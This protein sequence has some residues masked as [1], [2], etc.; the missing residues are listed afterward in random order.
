MLKRQLYDEGLAQ[1]R[2]DREHQEEMQAL[3]WQIANGKMKSSDLPCEQ[4]KL[5]MAWCKREEC[6]IQEKIRKTDEQIEKIDGLLADIAEIKK[7]SD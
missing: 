2:W 3:F 6:R 1:E 7:M 5:L 4:Q